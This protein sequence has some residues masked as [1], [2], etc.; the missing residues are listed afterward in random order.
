MSNGSSTACNRLLAIE[1]KQ[2]EVGVLII[3][4]VG[5]RH[6]VEEVAVTL[7][8]KLDRGRLRIRQWGVSGKGAG[9]RSDHVVSDS[10]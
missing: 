2:V 1:V 5:Y 3:E 8:P 7:H 6:N 10:E 4:V 9:V